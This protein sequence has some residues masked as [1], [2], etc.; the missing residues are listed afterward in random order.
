MKNSIE[1]YKKKYKERLN[2]FKILTK[3][4]AWFKFKT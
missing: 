3:C 4:N 1:K 2:K